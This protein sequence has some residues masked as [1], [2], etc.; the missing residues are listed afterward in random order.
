M[1]WVIFDTTIYVNLIKEDVFK[2]KK[3]NYNFQEIITKLDK[4]PNMRICGLSC[5]PDEIKHGLKGD[6]KEFIDSLLKTYEALCCVKY[7]IK[8]SYENLA[9]EY[10]KTY[11]KLKKKETKHWKYVKNDLLIY[12]CATLH[13]LDIVYSGDRETL[14]RDGF[15]PEFLNAYR[16]V[17]AGINRR[18]P[19]LKPY[20]ELTEYIKINY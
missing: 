17:N 13:G 15:A 4:D 3:K 19:E 8:K 7:K 5:I 12:A 6:K 14:S 11:K 10:Y 20:S 1:S 16:K 18:N 2:T 9:K